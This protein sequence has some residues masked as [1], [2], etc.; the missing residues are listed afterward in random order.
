MSVLRG[1]KAFIFSACLCLTSN[2]WADTNFADI[3]WNPAESGWGV[4]FAQEHNGAIFST[5]YAYDSS[6]K[7]V[8]LVGSMTAKTT[9]GPNRSYE[10]SLYEASGGSAL[11]LSS[12]NPASVTTTAVGTVQFVPESNFAG[13]LSYTYKGTAV[14]KR[15]ERF[16]VSG[17]VPPAATS[18][19][20]PYRAIA[21]TRNNGQ[22][23]SSFPL[24][25]TAG[26]SLRME[27]SSAASGDT[28]KFGLC[29]EGST[30]SCPIS[31]PICTFSGTGVK[32]HGNTLQTQGLLACTVSGSS[33]PLSGGKAGRFSAEF[34]LQRDDAGYSG[35]LVVQDTA[36][37]AVT[38][39]M[40]KSAGWINSCTFSGTSIDTFSCSN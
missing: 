19:G 32:Q 27:V 35:T 7:A 2:V 17:L 34:A 21:Q 23:S 11:T 37:V 26:L 15:I 18:A 14:A 8:W 12:F 33:N 30:T 40:L 13:N 20:S 22:C 6:G 25:S 10:G 28:Y 38:S 39:M 5:I 16:S 9:T 1:C 29:D 36:C 4:N 24:N 3:W 31:A